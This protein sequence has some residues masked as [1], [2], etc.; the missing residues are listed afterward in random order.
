M[1]ETKREKEREGNVSAS[2]LV[3]TF[4]WGPHRTH[5]GIRVFEYLS[6][7]GIGRGFNRGNHLC[8]TIGMHAVVF[9]AEGKWETAPVSWN[10]YVD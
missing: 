10:P 6:R 3:L 9:G 4:D 1:G 2:A 5:I 8:R 7:L